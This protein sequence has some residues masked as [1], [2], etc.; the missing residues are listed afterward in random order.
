M[1]QIVVVIVGILNGQLTGDLYTGVSQ[2]KFPTEQTC[3]EHK[4]SQQFQ[5]NVKKIIDSLKQQ[6][7]QDFT[8]TITCEDLDAKNPEEDKL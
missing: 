8:S 4:D 1:W 7:H 3:N 6:T 2:E 5:N